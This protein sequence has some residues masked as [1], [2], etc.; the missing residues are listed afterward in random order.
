MRFS[1][2]EIIESKLVDQLPSIRT[3]NDYSFNQDMNEIVSI[4]VKCLDCLNVKFWPILY[5]KLQSKS[6]ILRQ[7]INGIWI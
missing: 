2:K 7:Q 3:G 6:I 5:D 1:S 4:V